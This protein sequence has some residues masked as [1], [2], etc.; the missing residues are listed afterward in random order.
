MLT[1][2]EKE[3]GVIF[4]IRVQPRSSRT[5]IYGILNDTLKLHIAA[6]PTDDKANEECIHFLSKKFKV[7]KS[8]IQIMHGNKSREKLIKIHGITKVKMEQ[9]LGL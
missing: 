7:S 5:E 4:K 6:P 2:T 1:I 9:L 8:S 3:D